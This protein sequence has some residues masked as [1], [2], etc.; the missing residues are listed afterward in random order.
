MKTEMVSYCF[1]FVCEKLWW[2][3]ILQKG[4]DGMDEL[5]HHGI[6]GQK[7]GIRRFQNKDGTLTN[8]GKSRKTMNDVNDIVSTMSNKDRKLLGLHG[9]KYQTVDEGQ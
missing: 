3:Y 5:Y 4:G 8:L 2:T 7:W 1:V 6:K 9:K